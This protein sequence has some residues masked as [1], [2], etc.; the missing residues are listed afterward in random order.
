MLVQ[1]LYYTVMI[2]T[3]YGP[4][5]VTYITLTKA[6]KTKGMKR[7]ERRRKVKAVSVSESSHPH[8][9]HLRNREVELATLRQLPTN[10]NFVTENNVLYNL[11]T[12]PGESNGRFAC[13]CS[14]NEIYM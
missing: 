9:H 8:H 4:N 1:I 7:A 3:L 10:N 5:P 13:Q 14:G 6:H 2:I 12:F 11:H